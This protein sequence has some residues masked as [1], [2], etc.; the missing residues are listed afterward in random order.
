MP[1]RKS[2]SKYSQFRFDAGSLALN[3]VA[4][5]RHRGSEPN[6]LLS[7]P[8][9]LLQWFQLT[10]LISTPFSLSVDELEHACLFRESI[11]RVILSFIL[12]ERSEKEDVNLIND[13][14]R[15]PIAVPQLNLDSLYLEWKTANPLQAC[16][17][18]IARDA[19]MLIGSGDKGRLKICG[20]SS[21]QMLFADMSPS[22]R[23][24][25]CSMSICGNRHKVAEYRQRK[26]VA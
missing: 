10:G 21:C 19:V 8:E 26:N 20:S 24:R 2:C 18:K 13:M 5:V 7:K 9:A 16:F 1:R 17:S 4:T 25:W 12:G 14:A 11:Y 23:R 15:H 6:D 3:F 22:N